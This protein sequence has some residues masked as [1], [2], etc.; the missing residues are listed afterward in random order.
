MPLAR[1]RAAGPSRRRAPRRPALD[2]LEARTLLTA[3]LDPTFGLGGRASVPFDLARGEANGVALQ[4]DGKVVAVGSF[5]F[6]T[7]GDF[8][9]ARYNADGSLDP[10]F[11]RDGIA[12]I[13]IDLA[14]SLFDQARA[15]AIQ[16]DG[17]IVVA[18]IAVAGTGDNTDFAVARLNSNGTLDDSFSGD[19][20]ETIAFN[21]GGTNA[22][23]AFAVAIQPD[24]K[25]VVAG[26]CDLGGGDTDFAL[27]RLN[28][29]GAPDPTF[30]IDGKRTVHFDLGPAGGRQDDARSVAIQADGRIVVAGSA[31]LGGGN[32]DFAVARLDAFGSPD[33]TFDGDGKQTVA[34]NLG[35]NN[36]DVAFGLALQADGKV[37]LAGTV[38]QAIAGDR[39]FGVARLNPD[40][41]LDHSF[42]GDG[43]QWIAFDLGGGNTDQ[44]SAVAIQSDGKIVVVG[45]AT[46]DGP[47]NSNFAVARLNASG[48]LD[49]TFDGDGTRTIAFDLG[50]SN[51]DFAHSV[52]LQP[53]G[54]IVVAGGA[55]RL[56]GPPSWS[57]GLVRLNLDG[58]RDASFGADGIV[59]VPFGRASGPAADM[60]VQPDGRILIAGTIDQGGGN[61]DFVV[62]RTT[63]EGQSDPTFGAGTGRV[64]IP[65]DFGANNADF[66]SGIAL[67]PDGKII[68]VGTVDGQYGGGDTDF[69]VARLNPDG[70]LDPSFDT[71]GK[72]WIAFDLGGANAD[73]AGAVIVQPDGKIVVVGAAEVPGG[74]T[75]FAVAR[76]NPD[77]K[78]DTTFSFPAGAGRLTITFDPPGVGNVD[79]ATGVALQ[80]DGKIVVVGVASPGGDADFG[81]ARLNPDG[82]L[83]SAFSGDGK[84]TVAFNLGGA[85]DDLAEDVAIQDDG[86]IV[87]VGHATT[88]AAMNV[89]I[90]VARL[91]P[92]GAIDSAFGSNGK[93]TIAFDLGGNNADFGRAVALQG[94][95][96][97]VAGSAQLN[98]TGDFDF[99]IAR[100]QDDG[101]LDLSFNGDGKQYIGFDL[102]APF[103]DEAVALELLPG[104]RVLLAGTATAAPPIGGQLAGLARLNVSPVISVEGDYDGD[105]QTDLASYRYDAAAGAAAFHL[106]MSNFGAIMDATRTISGVGPR[107]VPVSGDFDGD[108]ITDVAVVD[109]LGDVTPGASTWILLL[110]GSGL[111]RRDVAFG[112]TGE[113][114]RPAPADYDGDGTTDIATFRADSDLVPG[115]AQWFILP[116]IPNDNG[117]DTTLG[118]FPVVFGAPGGTDLPAPADYDGD[119]RADIATFRP[120]SD[121][122]P[123]AADWFILP[124]GPNVPNY[125]TTSGGFNITFGASG[126]ADQPAVA[127]FNHDGRADIVAF[128]SDS[129]LVAGSAQWFILPS[130]GASPGYSGGFP[131]TFGTAGEIAAVGDYD[132]DGRPDLAVFDRDTGTWTLRS[133]TSAPDRTETFGPTGEG[134][135]PVLAPLYF[136]L[137]A[138]D[139]L[140]DGVASTATRRVARV[141]SRVEVIDRIL[142]ELGGIVLDP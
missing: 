22:D 94:D 48:S 54:R 60:V 80:E 132:R 44:A 41:S 23:G 130:S 110:S 33:P 43:K 42:S 6:G 127:D 121:L 16:P 92:D 20:I 18:G 105:G 138:T 40:G 86:K 70:T 114:D 7:T 128:R 96:I 71:D 101:T 68:V 91:N 64:I 76:L 28:P 122:H 98:L 19:G 140:S 131:V 116:S 47:S 99:A 30:D 62:A 81:I 137:R 84:Q 134:V 55:E 112:A 74:G 83:D 113:L 46:A 142:D 107:V 34:F 102:A 75:D 120:V 51:I 87:M 69:G 5:S 65:F 104:N 133:G 35:G 72:R 115:A 10:T 52:A 4:P 58:S 31:G 141:G 89:D 63:A 9:V 1:H 26:S 118:A 85:N 57:F 97:L 93:A 139:N 38:D 29:D 67:Q 61:Y 49:S 36:E 15:V 66:A 50:T 2:R 45:T 125:Q 82:T 78:L 3:L 117:F 109:P 95:R 124:S 73:V 90:A 100:L 106:R 108:G 12:T 13:A 103:G 119:G 32:F 126:N 79:R 25:I 17:K 24:G 59:A 11:S 37:V 56:P 14:D 21:L 123:G 39:D 136:R 88:A 111:A 8:G 129:D 27:V 135:V 77:G 53:D